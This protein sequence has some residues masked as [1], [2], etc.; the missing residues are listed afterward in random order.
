MSSFSTE[1]FCVLGLSVVLKAGLLHTD[2]QG[3]GLE[4]HSK[5]AKCLYQKTQVIW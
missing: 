1:L 3:G 4:L 5:Q 2:I